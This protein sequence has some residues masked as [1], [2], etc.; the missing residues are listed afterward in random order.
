MEI[1]IT[2]RELFDLIRERL[3]C[4]DINSIRIEIEMKGVKDGIY[5]NSNKEDFLTTE[6]ELVIANKFNNNQKYK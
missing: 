6:L 3:C 5:L 1:H 2:K 4:K